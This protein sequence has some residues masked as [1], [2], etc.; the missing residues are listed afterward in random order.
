[1]STKEFKKI[2]AEQGSILVPWSK[3]SSTYTVFNKA[4]EI[5]ATGDIKDL[6]RFWA[7]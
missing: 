2:L 4:G 6:K 3:G 7:Q 1:M 5:E